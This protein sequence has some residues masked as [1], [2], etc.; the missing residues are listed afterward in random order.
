[1]QTHNKVSHK[2]FSSMRLC[3]SLSA[4]LHQF[5][6]QAPT[7]WLATSLL[8]PGTLMIRTKAA[9]GSHKVT[10][11]YA[12]TNIF[13]ILDS[14]T[15]CMSKRK[16]L[17]RSNV[18]LHEIQQALERISLTTHIAPSITNSNAQSSAVRLPHVKIFIPCLLGTLT[19]FVVQ[20]G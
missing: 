16:V 18:V 5:I 8:R 7:P 12:Y 14:S 6:L 3:L 1:M 19:H 20:R 17:P 9:S 10:S 4:V 15:F 11:G 13:N 2:F